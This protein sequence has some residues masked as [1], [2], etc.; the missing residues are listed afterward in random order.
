MLFV[1]GLAV[2][3]QEPGAVPV[4]LLGREVSPAGL[5]ELSAERREHPVSD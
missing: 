4:G 2:Q 1:Q 5:A 3:R